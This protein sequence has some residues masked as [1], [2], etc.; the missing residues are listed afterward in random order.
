VEC[1]QEDCSGLSSRLKSEVIQKTLEAIRHDILLQVLPYDQAASLP[2]NILSPVKVAEVLLSP[3]DQE[4]SGVMASA[5]NHSPNLICNCLSILEIQAGVSLDD[6]PEVQEVTQAPPPCQS[7]S[8]L[9]PQSKLLTSP[10]WTP[11]LAL[12]QSSKDH[13]TIHLQHTPL[14]QQNFFNNLPGQ[15]SARPFQKIPEFSISP[16]LLNSSPNPHPS[17]ILDNTPPHDHHQTVKGSNN[18]TN[19]LSGIYR[20][21][22]LMSTPSASLAV[23]TPSLNA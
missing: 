8:Q 4:L 21:F 11:L 16:L 7:F 9:A 13:C 12:I 10:P 18:I 14:R 22:F 17:R 20:N 5:W 2:P 3:H 1:K 23:P 6:N 15:L 19:M